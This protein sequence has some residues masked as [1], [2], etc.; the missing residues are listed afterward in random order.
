MQADAYAQTQGLTLV[1]Y[2]HANQCI[3]NVDLGSLGKKIAEKIQSH[4]P[5]ACALLVGACQ[6]KHCPGGVASLRVNGV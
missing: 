5:Q 1:G 3:E 4:T 6:A 2:Y